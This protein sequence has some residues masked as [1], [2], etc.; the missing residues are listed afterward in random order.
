MLAVP[1]DK[2]GSSSLLNMHTESLP[3]KL[4]GLTIIL[5]VALGIVLLNAPAQPYPY[6]PDAFDYLQMAM[7]LT[8]GQGYSS[9]QATL[10]GLLFLRSQGFDT[11]AASATPMLWRYPFPVTVEAVLL[12]A[13]LEPYD[14]AIAFSIIG[15]SLT[16]LALFFLFNRLLGSVLISSILTMGA[17]LIQGQVALARSGMTEPFAQVFLFTLLVVTSNRGK[18]RQALAIGA[19]IGFAYLN[20]PQSLFYMLPLP[21]HRVGVAALQSPGTVEKLRGASCSGSRCDGPYHLP[22]ALSQC[23]RHR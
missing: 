18:T 15:Y 5:V 19:L 16:A 22:V 2:T 23:H 6:D 14:A 11:H 4:L 7:H 1:F 21:V 13:G 20:R 12:R 10:E 17:V 3:T 9:G 8:D